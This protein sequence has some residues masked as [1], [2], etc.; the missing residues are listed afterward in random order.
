MR[1][2]HVNDPIIRDNFKNAKLLI[3]EDNPDHGVVIKSAVRRSLPE[4]KYVL[5]TTESEALTY[6][7]ECSQEEWELPKLILLDLY[8]PNRQNGWRLLEQIKSMSSAMSK[9]PVVLL[10]NSNERSDI[11]EAYRRGCSSYLV[12]PSQFSDWLSYFQT[13][14]SYW[15]ETATLPQA[16]VSMF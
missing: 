7:N 1:I 5:A 11:A 10:S 12:K 3:I 8:L 13:L 4:V 6:L 14:R 15:W 2:R 9:I 16:S